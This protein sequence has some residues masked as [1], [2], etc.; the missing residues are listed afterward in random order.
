MIDL[1]AMTLSKTDYGVSAVY[2]TQL[3]EEADGVLG[4]LGKEIRNELVRT[5]RTV[6]QVTGCSDL[7][8]G[9]QL[10][11]QAFFIIIIHSYK[12]LLLY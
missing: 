6:L 8:N 3:T 11:K 9:F 12:K 10:L 7:S 5:R 2:E 1:I 4:D